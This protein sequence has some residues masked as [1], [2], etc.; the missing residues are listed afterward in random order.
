[1]DSADP[2][3]QDLLRSDWGATTQ[4]L[5]SHLSTHRHTSASSTWAVWTSFC[6]D[7]G[8]RPDLLD[9]HGDRLP[10]LL[11]FAQLYRFGAV[12][13]RHQPVRSCTVEDAL[14]RVAQTFSRVGAAD[15]RL[16]AFCNL[17]FRLQALYNAWK[18]TDS[19]PTRVKP[20]SLV[21]L[22]KAHAESLASASTI[23][24]SPAGDCLLLAYF[25]LLRPGEYSGAPQ[26]AVDNLFRIQD[27]GVWI[28]HRRLDPLQA[29]DADLLA[30]TFVTLTFTNQK[31]GV[32]GET[33]GHGR[34]GNPTLCH[35]A[36]LVRRLL[37][38]RHVGAVPSTPINAFR[39]RLNDPWLF[40][41]P[42]DITNLLCRSVR[43]LPPSLCDFPIC[44]TSARST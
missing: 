10:V 17:D 19:P 15:P 11:L 44:D 1:M 28:G 18:K 3:T 25:F 4:A 32:R 39:A 14:R 41:R 16:N 20:L 42:I 40:V 9:V 35:V 26:T 38:L 8:V 13:P 23:R 12:A 29:P 30:V 43:L 5:N 31:N 7:V 36:A 27:C 37:Y 21:V 33:I 22:R 6:L 24:M 34:S 2:H